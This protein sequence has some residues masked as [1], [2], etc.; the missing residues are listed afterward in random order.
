MKFTNKIHWF[1]TFTLLLCLGLTYASFALVHSIAQNRS[2]E[3]FQVLVDQG[4]NSLGKRADEYRR[5]LDGVSGLVLA[6]DEVTGGDMASYA[7]ALDIDDNVF[8]IDAVGFARVTTLETGDTQGGYQVELLAPVTGHEKLV[9]LNFAQFPAIMDAAE[10]ARETGRVE[11]AFVPAEINGK[12]YRQVMLL[13]PVYRD[14]AGATANGDVAGAFLGFS[15]ALLNLDRTFTKLTPSHGTLITLDVAFADPAMAG[16]VTE[17]G[18]ET[19]QHRALFTTQKTIPVYGTT[20]DLFWRSTPRFEAVQPFRARWVVLSMGLLITALICSIL[21]VLIKMNQTVTALVDQRTRDL[22]TQ[23]KEKQ[24]I[25]ENA[26][27]AI[28]SVCKDGKIIHA[29]GAGLALLSPDSKETSLVGQSIWDLVPDIDL[30]GIAMWSKLHM[31]TPFGPDKII[32]V[33][34]NTWVTAD[35]EDRITLLMRDI[36]ATEHHAQTLAESEQR[37]NLAL[38]SAQIGVYDLD[39]HNGTSVVSDTWRETLRLNP[40]ADERDPYRH[41]MQ[42]IHADDL[43]GLTQAQ[44]ACISGETERAEASFRVKVGENEWRWIKSNAVVVER[45]PDG[46]ALR[47][48]GIQVDVTE[49]FRLEQMKR[50][51]VAT[52]SH[53]L[54]TPLTSIKGALSLLDM[55]LKDD[56]GEPTKRL[57]QIASSN[58]DR[59]SSLVNDILDI[60]KMRS[61]SMTYTAKME[62]LCSIMDMASDQVETYA[63]QWQVDIDVSAPQG[64]HDIWTDK[65]RIMQV[66]ANLLSN[67]C[68]FADTGT[69]VRLSAE[70]L[71]DCARISVS[72]RG[73]GIPQSFRSQIFQPFS[74]A[75]TSETRQRGGTGLGLNI[76]RLLV[77][78]MGGTIGFESEPGQET[79]FW[80]TCPLTEPASVEI[81]A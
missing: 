55:Q 44:A 59:L 38:T 25:L 32:E 28:I 24:S 67:A 56:A 41:Q 72:N 20:L 19:A 16:A 29:N 69:T 43:D 58:S 77:E 63:S 6:S 70:L 4:M 60:E 73:P 33:E 26:M 30:D 76:S 50:D 22:E 11:S 5:T 74:Q 9:S 39:L 62:K 66:L 46:T 71:E 31:P 61:G 54:R 15:F 52:V 68:K 8:A 47:M 80:F 23:V 45:M 57:I 37:W 10:D 14:A 34:K 35:G 79:V 75:D 42:N 64:D 21:G 78:A 3:N 51:F 2:E 13:R 17:T 53:E 7:N 12:D 1:Q 81:A 49:T 36:T 65:K 48:L 27:M 18:T 40:C